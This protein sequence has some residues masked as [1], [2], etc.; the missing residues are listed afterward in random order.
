MLSHSEVSGCA[1]T[2]LSLTCCWF[3]L[4]SRGCCSFYCPGW[5][6]V[7]CGSTTLRPT[8]SSWNR[9][10][11]FLPCSRSLQIW[12]IWEGCITDPQEEQHTTS[13]TKPLLF[14]CVL[15]RIFPLWPPEVSSFLLCKN[16]LLHC[17]WKPADW[18][19]WLQKSKH[20]RRTTTF[21]CHTRGILGNWER[22]CQDHFG[23]VWRTSEVTLLRTNEIPAFIRSSISIS[24]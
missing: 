20:L 13:W 14:H 8:Q 7:L 3:L 17:L 16:K 5:G 11:L 15:W 24:H 10:V 23:S 12:Q 21:S 22:L 6:A 4:Y 18:C 1:P 19:W 9:W 2:L